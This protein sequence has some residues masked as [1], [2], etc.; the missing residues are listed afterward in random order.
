MDDRNAWV[1][2][3]LNRRQLLNQ[4][5]KWGVG[6][7]GTTT[8]AGLL[9]AC[10]AGPS[11]TP[12]A[13][14]GIV[15][16]TLSF[17][18]WMFSEV[19]TNRYYSDLAA[20]FH[21]KYPKLKVQLN[22]LSAGS[23]VE[24]IFTQISGGSVPDI[25]PLFTTQMPQYIH[26][27]LLK[28]LDSYLAT[29][30]FKDQLLPLQSVAVKNGK[31]YGVVLTASPQGLIVNEQLL[32]KAGVSVPTTLDELYTAADKI[33]RKTGAFGFG[34]AADASD[35][36]L[37]YVVCQQWV[38]G[39]GSNFSKPNGTITADAPATVEG[40]VQMMRFVNAPFAPKGLSYYQLRTL[41][42]QGKLAML[43][44]GP[45]DLGQV[46]AQNAA[47]YPAIRM[48]PS[49]TPTHA[50]ITGGAFYSILNKEAHPQDV[51]DFIAFATSTEWQQRWMDVE[52]QTPAIQLKPSSSFLHANPGYAMVPEI[53]KKYATGF[54]Y[55]PPGYELNATQFQ[56]RVI[57]HV[58]AIW[59]GTQSPKAAMSA[60]Q[61]DLESWASSLHA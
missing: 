7:A 27:G 22:S 1:N 12:S 60:C 19:D 36:L 18:S 20:A 14:S 3:S 37:A 11:S 6:I 26:L 13:S 15:P 16:A 53:A 38:L 32:A 61:K 34:V 24:E 40:F 5:M 51:W 2:P 50:A 57:N 52:I 10:G 35:M 39:N 59:A 17:P 42:A 46:K 54:G 47:L 49:P 23:Y 41:L 29:A 21:K 45:W 58:A 33:H 4:S 31:T 48:T 25:L 28:P 9:A 44:D 56:T 43:I 55:F 30:P 8:L